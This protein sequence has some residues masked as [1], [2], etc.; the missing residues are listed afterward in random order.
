M[1]P[2]FNLIEQ[3]K[4]IKS[5]IDKAIQ[6]VLKHGQYIMGPEVNELEKRLSL[7]VNSKNVISCASGTDALLIYLMSKKLKK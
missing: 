5:Q 3:Q 7:F 6:S 1:I 4:T 2:F